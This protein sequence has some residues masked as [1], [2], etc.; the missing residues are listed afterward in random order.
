MV[1]EG[2]T[3]NSDLARRLE[4]KPATV[5]QHLDNL[6]GKFGVGNKA[7]LIAAVIKA[8]RK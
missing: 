1:E 8:L 5:K 3:E 4:V 7:S 2:A 6:F